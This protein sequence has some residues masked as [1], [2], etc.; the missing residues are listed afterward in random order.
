MDKNTKK[1]GFV[2]IE[3]VTVLVLVGI[4]GVFAGFFL[5][6]GV[7]GYLTSKKTSEGALQA[8]AALERISKELIDLSS[9]PVAPT[10]TSVTYTSSRSELPGQ[11]RISYSDSDSV[12]SISVDGTAY[13]LLANVSEFSLSWDQADLDADGSADDIAGFIVTFKIE[14]IG[15][16]FST[17]IYP[18]RFITPS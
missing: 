8:Q 4:I 15:Q 13:P 18:R 6:T 17:R 11:R 7:Q 10:A 1:A 9:L 3:L 2:L 14:D 5:F 16:P 12:I